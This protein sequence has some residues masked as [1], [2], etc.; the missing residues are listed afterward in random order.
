MSSVSSRLPFVYVH[1]RLHLNLELTQWTNTYIVHPRISTNPLVPPSARLEHITNIVCCKRPGVLFPSIAGQ[2]SEWNRHTVS[3]VILE[4]AKGHRRPMH[5]PKTRTPYCEAGRWCWLPTCKLPTSRPPPA[6][7]AA[8]WTDG[9]PNLAL[10]A[11]RWWPTRSGPTPSSAPS[12][13]SR[14]FR[15]MIIGWRLV[16]LPCL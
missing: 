1:A 4:R 6:N 3:L 7:D 11:H 12:R 14:L 15:A 5:T 10:P 16:F 8:G 13:T 2:T 9:Q